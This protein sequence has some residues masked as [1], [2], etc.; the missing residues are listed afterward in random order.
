MEIEC[1]GHF[2]FLD[3]VIYRRPDSSL[4]HRVYKSNHTNLYLKA[5]FH[6]QPSYEQAV[7]STL[8]QRARVL[9]NEDRQ[10]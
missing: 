10:Q 2:L 8:V 1:E 9:C 3:I 6:H 5:K 7:L 4:S